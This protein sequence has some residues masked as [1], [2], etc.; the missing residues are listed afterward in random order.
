[1]VTVSQ[2]V[3]TRSADFVT[4]HELWS[5][6]QYE[7]ADRVQKE[8]EQSGLE[9]IRIS[10]AD[11]HG[12][13]RGKTLTASAF[14]SALR[15]GK[16]FQTS[17]LIMDTTNN[18]FV[19]LFTTGGGFGIPEMTG[20]PDSILVPDPTTFRVLPWSPRTGWVL[21]DMHFSNGSPVPFST[22][23]ILR[24]ALKELAALGYDYK[25]GLE[26]EFYITKL[27]NPMLKAEQAGWPPDAP[28]VTVVAH[29]FQYLTENRGA[30]IDPIVQILSEN[31]RAVGLPLNTIEDEWGPGQTEFTFEPLAGLAPADSMILFRT[32]AK[33]ICRQHGYHATF[34]CRPALPNF[35]S[36]GWHLHQS[37]VALDSGTNAFMTDD[38][39]PVSDL[40]RYFAGGILHHAAASMVFSTPTVNGYKRYR[41]NSFAPDRATW[42]YENRGAMIRVSGGPGD[43]A[44]HLENRAG[45]PAA[46]PYLYMAAQI[47]AGIDGVQNKIDPGPM[48]DEPYLSNKPLLPSSL[49]EAVQALEKSDFFREK[50]GDAFVNY[51]VMLKSS[52]WAR[53]LSTPTD[54]E[55]REYFEVY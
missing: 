43:P 15:N 12:I 34:M 19:P 36:S 26:V 25:A 28:E 47:F 10:W 29:G 30:E 46:N 41:P 17:T 22:R 52:E 8:I 16:D 11:Q 55:Q 33:Q 50:M 7:A 3:P 23:G 48:S 51:M 1:M 20:F 35:F 54:W 24:K 40:A 14:K 18:I 27:E 31:L 4:R 13:A 44:T 5:D 42:S 49:G 6:E 45:E 9:H 53:F 21:S 2:G 32:A 37:L 39:G 38:S